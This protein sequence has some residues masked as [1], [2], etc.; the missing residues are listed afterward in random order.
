MNRTARS[1]ERFIRRTGAEVRRKGVCALS[2]GRTIPGGESTDIHQGFPRPTIGG[3]PDIS[4]HFPTPAREDGGEWP[5]IAGTR[6]LR[7]DHRYLLPFTFP[8]ASIDEVIAR[9]GCAIIA[10]AVICR[11]RPVGITC[12]AL[13]NCDGRRQSGHR[14][15]PIRGRTADGAARRRLRQPLSRRV[16]R[17]PQRRRSLSRAERG[18]SLLRARL[19]SPRRHQYGSIL[20]LRHG[21]RPH[22]PRSRDRGVGG[23]SGRGH[24][25]PRARLQRDQCRPRLAG[26]RRGARSLLA[27]AVDRPPRPHRSAR[28]SRRGELQHRPRA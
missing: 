16:R 3:S 12:G 9:L 18:K 1:R 13:S 14:R 27:L 5:L 6:I 28:G 26:D 21:T 23:L 10:R 20:L 19:R 17:P 15:R 7:H 8:A 2:G 11:A 24:R 25:G 22:Q 4:R